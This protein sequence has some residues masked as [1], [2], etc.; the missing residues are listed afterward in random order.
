MQAA[1]EIEQL[2]GLR[3]SMEDELKRLRDLA[4]KVERALGSVRSAE[5]VARARAVQADANWLKE[6]REQYTE[7]VCEKTLELNG[8][9][10]VTEA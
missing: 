5:A 7:Q 2:A 10:P 1:N 9:F 3:R 6:L 8:Q 4:E